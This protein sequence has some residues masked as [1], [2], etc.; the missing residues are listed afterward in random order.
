MRRRQHVTVTL[1]RRNDWAAVSGSV[2]RDLIVELDKKLWWS[3]ARRSWMTNVRTASDLMALAD[4]RGVRVSYD[5][6]P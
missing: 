4:S 5:E 2:A 6:E 3:N 1:C